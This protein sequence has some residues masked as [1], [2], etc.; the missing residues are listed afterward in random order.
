MAASVGHFLAWRKLGRW[1]GR[2]PLLT[3][4]SPGKLLLR[5]IVIS[6]FRVHIRPNGRLASTGELGRKVR[7]TNNE[8]RETLKQAGNN[9]SRFSFAGPCRRRMYAKAR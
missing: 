8:R 5:V 3:P 7:R 6:H 9:I 4:D 1:C 2:T